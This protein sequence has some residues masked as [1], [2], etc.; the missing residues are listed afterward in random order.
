M[1]DAKPTP[2]DVAH[3]PLDFTPMLQ[4]LSQDMDSLTRHA[5]T[6]AQIIL[7]INAILTA[8]ASGQARALA[9][10]T[11]LQALAFACGIATLVLMIASVYFSLRTVVPRQVRSRGQRPRNLFFYG[12]MAAMAEGEY[13]A[14]FQTLTLAD[15]REQVLAQA[16]AKAGV[17]AAKFR[18]V[19][20]AITL[21]FAAVTVW[22]VGR[23]LTTLI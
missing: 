5:D 9:A 6:K 10:A 17:V 16:H 1:D 3:Q 2:A 12:D 22:L 13:V 14:A 15:L 21:L 19:R 23:I 20:R 18:N 4:M 8:T 7:A 11:P